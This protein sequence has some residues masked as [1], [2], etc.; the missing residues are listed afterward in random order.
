MNFIV[1]SGCHPVKN[2][3][4]SVWQMVGKVSSKVVCGKAVVYKNIHS[5]VNALLGMVYFVSI[6]MI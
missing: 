2:D 5:E 3:I 4:L 1:T 6:T